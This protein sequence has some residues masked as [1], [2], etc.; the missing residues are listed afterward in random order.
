M[1]A[2]PV[3]WRHSAQLPGHE[4][5]PGCVP[6]DGDPQRGVRDVSIPMYGWLQATVWD[7]YRL[8]P[9]TEITGPAVLEERESSCWFGPECCLRVDSD[10]TLLVGVER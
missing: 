4:V 3:N 7:R 9:G 2:S 6:L 5:S 1:S 8:R 10:L